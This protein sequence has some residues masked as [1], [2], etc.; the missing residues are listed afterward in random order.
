MPA[1]RIAASVQDLAPS[2]PDPACHTLGLEHGHTLPGQGQP[3]PPL[4]R[5]LA[6]P[7]P[8][9][10]V[11]ME[12]KLSEAVRQ[13][14]RLEEML[15]MQQQSILQLQSVVLKQGEALATMRQERQAA[16]ASS[17]ESPAA[18]L[19]PAPPHAGGRGS[20]AP[21]RAAAIWPRTKFL[22]KLSERRTIYG[23][24]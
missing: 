5:M 15:Q 22:F 9:H 17:D 4:D 8:E 21:P 16:T 1:V 24:R 14:Q 3:L 23:L 6:V 19:S 13:Q 10:P 18:K 20:P 12:Q 2:V 7:P 11:A